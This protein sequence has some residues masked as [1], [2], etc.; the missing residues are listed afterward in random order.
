[1]AD[2]LNVF[3]LDQELLD[4]VL[5]ATAPRL[6]PAK[7]EAQLMCTGF[8]K[9]AETGGFI[10]MFKEANTGIDRPYL[11]ATFESFG[12]KPDDNY[13]TVYHFLALP[14]KG[15][16][17]DKKRQMVL[18][19]YQNFFKAL[20]V[21][22]PLKLDS[23]AFVTGKR[24]RAIMGIKLDEEYGDKSTIKKFILPGEEGKDARTLPANNEVSI[25]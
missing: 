14:Y 3:E 18:F 12:N 9:D 21:K 8:V 15:E 20:G 4:E 1:M 16:A 10:R 25:F 6:Y 24:C 11:Q 7:M 22:P 19:N 23:D 17:T 2:A 13:V 5:V